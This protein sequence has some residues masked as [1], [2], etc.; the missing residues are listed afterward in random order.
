MAL[1]R[2]AG[3]R[4]REKRLDRGLRQSALAETVGISAS[5]LNLIEHNRRRIGGK[6]LADLA[7]AL[8]VDT[9]FLTEGA[10]SDMLDQLRGAAGLLGSQVEVARAEEMAARFPGWSALIAAQAR[11]IAMLQDQARVLNDRMAHDPQLAGALHAVISAVTSIRSSASILIGPEKLD[12]DWQRRF[13]ANIHNDSLRLAA[14]SEA[15]IAYL[16]A[17]E[18]ELDQLGSPFEQ[19]EGYLAQTGF[20]LAALEGGQA[21]ADGVVGDAGLTGAAAIILHGYASQYLYDAALLPMASFQLGCRAQGYDPAALA[22]TFGVPFPAVLRRLSTLPQGQGHPPFG[23][24]HCDAAGSLTLVK[25]VPGFSIPRFG[26]ACP[27]WPLFS[28]LGRPAQAIRTDVM[29]PGPN[30]AR[31]RCFAIAT[32]F[33]ATDFDVPPAVQ[34]TMLVMPDPPESAAPPLPVGISCR[35]C[36]RADCAS[37][38]EPALPGVEV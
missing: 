7:R 34:S 32:Q 21:D 23:L 28:A 11:R 8:G 15:L 38:R 35:I 17:P 3:S 27:L 30:L 16:E 4:I 2:L 14:S 26:G 24:A 20:H 29:L 31:L 12:D 19:V 13:H 36:P 10:D 18:A 33:A 9:A 5:Y 25:T 1:Q 6:L 37:R 22:R